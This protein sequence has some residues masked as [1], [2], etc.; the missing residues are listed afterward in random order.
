[1]FFKNKEI[2]R[3]DEKKEFR[4]VLFEAQRKFPE[5][6]QAQINY[7]KG[8][9][10]P[11]FELL[12]NLVLTQLEYSIKSNRNK[13]IELDPACVEYTLR[14]FLDMARHMQDDLPESIYEYINGQIECFMEEL[15]KQI[16]E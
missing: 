2:I 13:K 12:G 9:G 7:I 1:M 3:H 10:N 14:G 4:E 8:K 15:V 5:D 6:R 16:Q 11:Q